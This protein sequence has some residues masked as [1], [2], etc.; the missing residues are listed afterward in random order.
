MCLFCRCPYLDFLSR[1]E[2]ASVLQ[3]LR[4]SVIRIKIRAKYLWR[5]LHRQVYEEY[6]KVMDD[7]VS[8]WTA[9]DLVLLEIASF[10][11]EVLYLNLILRLALEA[12]RFL[13]P[14]CL[15]LLAGQSLVL[16]ANHQT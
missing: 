9:D 14:V 16:R 13:N 10:S 3:N 2:P 7:G 5:G 15:H 6:P 12:R 8:E 1:R 11:E 4:K